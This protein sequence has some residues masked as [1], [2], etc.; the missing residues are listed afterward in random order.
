MA[1]IIGLPIDG[2]VVSSWIDSSYDFLVSQSI[3]IFGS[4]PIVSGSSKFY[5]KLAWIHRIRDKEP[6]DTLESIQ[7]YVRCQIFCLL[8]STIFVDKS[9]AYGH[10]KYQPP[11]TSPLATV[12]SGTTSICSI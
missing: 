10:V 4:K 3:A 1:H 2:E 11:A 9:T 8:G 6:L 7:R 5:I 12:A